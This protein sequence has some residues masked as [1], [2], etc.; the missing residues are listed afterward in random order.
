MPESGSKKSFCTLSQPPSPSWSIANWPGR[1][2]NFFRF[3]ARTLLMI[4]RYPRSA[5]TCWAAGVFRKRMNR[6]AAFLF[7][8]DL[9][10]A[11]GFSIRIVE[12]G[13]TYCTLWPASWAP[14][15]SFS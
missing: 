12:R 2:G 3:L 9:M 4:G 13:I 7:G 10:T 5:K 11:I 8:L 1:T 6:F 15:A 14:I